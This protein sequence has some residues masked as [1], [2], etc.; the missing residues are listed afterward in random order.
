MSDFSYAGI[1]RIKLKGCIL[2]LNGIYRAIKAPLNDYISSL[3]RTFE[4]QSYKKDSKKR[5]LSM[6]KISI[7]FY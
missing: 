3:R 4:M 7:F 1:N 5:V 2:S 6:Q